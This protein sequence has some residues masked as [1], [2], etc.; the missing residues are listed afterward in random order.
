[1]Q[2]FSFS[3]EQI[4]IRLLE[5]DTNSTTESETIDFKVQQIMK[6]AGYSTTNFNNDIALLRID[7][8]FKFDKK[9]K[10]V[11]LPERGKCKF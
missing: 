9:L 8:Q 11:C 4:S 6:H 7:G 1:M 2:H 10:P 3:R 5:H